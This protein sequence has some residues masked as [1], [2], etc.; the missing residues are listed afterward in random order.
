MKNFKIIVC[1]LVVCLLLTGCGM[2]MNIGLEVSKNKEV[3]A[4]IISA[5]DNEMI[6]FSISSA[7]GEESEQSK[8]YTDAERWE[9][10]EKNDEDSY[11]G[12]KKERY[13]QDSNIHLLIP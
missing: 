7:N 5:M 11:E 3:Q 6:D 2:R 12:Y 13:D 1:S 4:K 8:T 10:V 9:Y